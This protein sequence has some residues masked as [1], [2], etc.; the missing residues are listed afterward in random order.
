MPKGRR[1]RKDVD[2][3][4]DSEGGLSED[5]SSD[6]EQELQEK[7][8]EVS[9]LEGIDLGEGD[10]EEEENPTIE[11]SG[12]DVKRQ[13]KVDLALME[14]PTEGGKYRITEVDG[15]GNPLER[16]KVKDLSKRKEG[17]MK[18]VCPFTTNGG[19][20]VSWVDSAALAILLDELR[21]MT[22]PDAPIV[23]SQPTYT[24]PTQWQA[25]S[26]YPQQTTTTQ[27]STTT[28]SVFGGFGVTQPQTQTT[29]STST[30]GG[31]G[32]TQPQTQTTTSTSTWGG[33]G[34]TQPS[35][36]TSF[37]GFTQPQ[38]STT[39]FPGFGVTQPSTGTSFPGFAMSQSST[40]TT[41]TSSFGGWTAPTGGG[42]AQTTGYQ[43]TFGAFGQSSTGVT[44]PLS[45]GFSSQG[46][47]TFGGG[48]VP[49]LSGNEYKFISGGQVKATVKISEDQNIAL[50]QLNFIQNFLTSACG[51][52]TIQKLG[53]SRGC[54]VESL[55]DFI[56]PFITISGYQPPKSFGN[57]PDLVKMAQ[58]IMV[59][60]VRGAKAKGWVVDGSGT[61]GRV[62]SYV[63]SML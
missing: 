35:T 8:E 32:V 62:Y 4:V 21:D 19:G 41:T 50:Q 9:G 33:F 56:R 63:S 44:A 20:A 37:G 13:P 36:G 26:F 51:T 2:S 49:G 40:G 55:K 11:P 53:D 39:S 15:L 1:T 10:E 12:F 57:K 60:I 61:Y 14:D 30:W 42:F 23:Q 59:A 52:T 54:T 27:P 16:V 17:K 43:P 47:G 6:E 29:T 58:G 34:V 48:G 25:P 38:P 3:D 18:P 45:G 22:P 7:E 46:F 24:Q 31:F 28:G 5:L